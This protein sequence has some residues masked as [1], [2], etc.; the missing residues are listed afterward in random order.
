MIR[1]ILACD[2]AGGIAKNGVM[3]WPHNSTDLAH[4]KKITQNNTVLMGR[5]TWEAPD[6]PTPLPGR[7]NLVLTRDQ[8][9]TAQGASVLALDSLDALEDATARGT[10]Y[11][12]G[13]A[14]LF[15]QF[16]DSISIFHLTRIA[17]N[18]ECDTHIDLDKVAKTFILLDSV[19]VD[20]NTTFETYMSRRIHD[21]SVDPKF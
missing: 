2:G 10:V 13:G 21:L 11:L 16:I 5:K 1:A 17:G 3:P 6:M 12:I 14:E 9:Y 4:F 20:T 7:K 19:R 15:H 18:W 8:R